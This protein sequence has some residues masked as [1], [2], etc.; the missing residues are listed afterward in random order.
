M[1]ELSEK[2]ERLFDYLKY[3]INENGRTP[4][5]RQAA[6]DLGITHAAVSQLLKALEKKG[7]VRRD[8]RYGRSIEINHMFQTKKSVNSGIEIPI[9]GTIA[10]GLPLYAQQIWSGAVLVDPGIYKG[11]NLF[12][13]RI[14]GDSMK[15]AAILNGD[16]VICEPRQ[17]AE[18]GD[19]VAALVNSSD[20]TVKRFY[21]RGEEVELRPENKNYNPV[22]YSFNNILI[23]GKV[24]GV[25]RPPDGID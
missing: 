4:S 7:A 3:F 13:L 25:I 22:R 8:G 20:A 21:N 24:I 1:K 9:V 15:D 23:Q 6:A 11:D 10:A 16:I 5:L 17:L 18:N 14:E 2:Q 12:A 19:I